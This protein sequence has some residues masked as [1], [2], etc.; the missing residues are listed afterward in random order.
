MVGKCLALAAIVFSQRIYAVEPSCSK[1]DKLAKDSSWH[2][3]Y[4]GEVVGKGRLQFY[5]APSLTCKIKGKFII[6]GDGVSIYSEYGEW[7]QIMYPE[8]TEE[9]SGVWVLS[10]RLKIL[11][12]PEWGGP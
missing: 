1:L 5:S 9:D 2:R 8:G 6:E 3:P 12:K 10:N 4:V 7:S 11:S